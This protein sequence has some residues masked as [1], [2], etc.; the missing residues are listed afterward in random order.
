MITYRDK[1][2]CASKVKRHTCGRYLDEE[3]EKE[4]A[5]MGLP[6]AWGNF[7]ENTANDGSIKL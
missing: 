4:A 3:N 6:I 1:T 2:Y 5:R 7:C